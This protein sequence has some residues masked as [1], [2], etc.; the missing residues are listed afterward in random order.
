MPI[1]RMLVVLAVVLVS[2]AACRRAKKPHVGQSFTLANGLRVELEPGPCGDGAVVAVLFAVG[3]DHDPTGRSGQANLI[4]RLLARP[5][6]I[7]SAGVDHTAYAATVP[8][9]G[10]LDALD[11][12]AAEMVRLEVADAD[13]ARARA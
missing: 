11:R 3:A 2:L 1:R 8:R 10:L 6:R 13:V 7:V 4:A 9:D 5:E 12:V